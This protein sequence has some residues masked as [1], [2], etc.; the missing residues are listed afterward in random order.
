MSAGESPPSYGA[1]GGLDAPQRLGGRMKGAASQ[2]LDQP[3]SEVVRPEQAVR[4][5]PALAYGA[6]V[7]GSGATLYDRV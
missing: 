3:A 2:A 1:I 6:P 5:H 4:V 7:A